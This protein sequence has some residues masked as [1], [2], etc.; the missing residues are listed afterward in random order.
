ME[1]E[2]NASS[3]SIAPAMLRVLATANGRILVTCEE[4][5]FLK[6]KIEDKS[7]TEKLGWREG[8][9]GR[10]GERKKERRRSD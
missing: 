5:V 7:A 10:E 2:L 1:Q 8:E 3:D 9:C 4:G 6:E